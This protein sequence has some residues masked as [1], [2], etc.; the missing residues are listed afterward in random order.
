MWSQTLSH[1]FSYFLCPECMTPLCVQVVIVTHRKS[2]YVKHSLCS[3]LFFPA[4][5]LALTLAKNTRLWSIVIVSLC[6]VS[7]SVP[8]PLS[9][10]AIKHIL[11]GGSV[12]FCSHYTPWILSSWI[13]ESLS[14]PFWIVTFTFEKNQ[15]PSMIKEACIGSQ[16]PALFRLRFYMIWWV[17]AQLVVWGFNH[18][19]V[20]F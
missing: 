12:L 10:Y 5:P 1:Q 20:S 15:Y 11:Q 2:F 4:S 13:K 19:F 3:C 16:H 17:C 9:F 7:P 18:S 6:L 14:M 8:P